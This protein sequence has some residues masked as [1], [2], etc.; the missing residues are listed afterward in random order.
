VIAEQMGERLLGYPQFAFRDDPGCCSWVTTVVEND[1][2]R[3]PTSIWGFFNVGGFVS[4]PETWIGIAVGVAL[5]V[6][7]IQ[8]R[9]RRTEI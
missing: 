5:V 1:T 3:T 8:L 6:G 9:T 4:S 2:L 7:A